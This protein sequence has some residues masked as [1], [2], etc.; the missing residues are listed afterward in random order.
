MDEDP[1]PSKKMTKDDFEQWKL[2]QDAEQKAAAAAQLA[3]R[4]ADLAAGRI[5]AEEM[6]GRELAEHHPEVFDGY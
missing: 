3:Q 1:P 6:T 4:E 2:N 5:P